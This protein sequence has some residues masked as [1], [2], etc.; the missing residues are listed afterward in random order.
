MAFSKLALAVAVF[1]VVVSI[2]YYFG[3]VRTIFWGKNKTDE[4]APPPVTV[5]LP[6]RIVLGCC[7]AAMLYL[8]LLPNK[9]VKWAETAA[10][11]EASRK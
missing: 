10:K 3:I 6:V 4:A 8:G 9:P 11:V 5:G 7:V 2:Y 1:G